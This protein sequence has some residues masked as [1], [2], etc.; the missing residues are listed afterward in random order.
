VPDRILTLVTAVAIA[1]SAGAARAQEAPRDDPGPNPPAVALHLAAL[2]GNVE[3]IRQ[4]VAAGSDL[5]QVDAYGSTPLLVA[6]TFGRPD[7]ARALVEAGADLAI[8]NPEGSTPLHVAAYLGRSQIAALLLEH[9]AD[10]HTRNDDG[11]A[12]YDMAAVPVAYDRPLLDQLR[13]GLAPL[14]LEL[15]DER[16][17]G[18]RAGIIELLRSRR[19]DLEEIEFAPV[20]AGGWPVSTPAAQGLNPALVADLYA[21]AAQLEAIRGLLI[22]KDGHLVAERYFHDSAIDRPTLVQ[23][24]TKSVTSALVGIALERGCLESLDQPMLDFFPEQA[25]RVT[26][27]R[28]QEITIREM[29]QMRAGYGWEGSD[30]VRWEGLI[31]GDYLPLLVDFPLDRDPGTGFDYSNV[32]SHL[33]AVIV[34]RACDTDL[35]P[36]AQEHLFDP[37]GVRPGEWRA[38]RYGYHFGQGELHLTARDMARF[39]LLYLNDGVWQGRQVVPAAWVDASRTGYSSGINTAGLRSGTVGRYF[40][41]AEYGYQWWS[42]RVGDRRFPFAWGHGGQ[43]I[44]LLDDLNMVLV[45]TTDPFHRPIREDAEA[46]KHEQATFNLIGRF[47]RSLPE[48]GGAP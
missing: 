3:A 5:D 31:S 1:S 20:A 28:K 41:D 8:G 32:T 11:A 26:D 45:V 4:H 40:R 47:I 30:S 23:S 22:V 21:D 48:Q 44:V 14:G 34:A 17:A 39:G 25:A 37:I 42:A 10:P 33:L 7:A 35:L 38:D 9:R 24:V 15:D 36:F 46:W 29:L 16:I 19:A 12:P 13:A 43:M 18:G 2:Q 6:T 27:P